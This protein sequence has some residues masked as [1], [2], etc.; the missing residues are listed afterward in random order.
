[1]DEPKLFT[2]D[3]GGRKEYLYGPGWKVM[4]LLLEGGFSTPE[5]AKEQWERECAEERL[6]GGTRC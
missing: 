5:E 2:K 1:M 6:R 3:I 4:E